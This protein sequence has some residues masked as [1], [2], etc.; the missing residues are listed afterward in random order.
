LSSV[1]YFQLFVYVIILFVGLGIFNIDTT[2]FLTI[3]IS[4]W[5]GTLFAIGGVVKNL[6][7][8]IVFLFFT[9]PYDVGDRLIIDGETL[10]VKEFGLMSTTFTRW[11]GSEIYSPNIVLAASN[12]HNVKRRCVFSL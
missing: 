1:T 2:A 12:I 8:S 4:L 6:I 3:S 9:H 5:A 11:D 10:N 7:E